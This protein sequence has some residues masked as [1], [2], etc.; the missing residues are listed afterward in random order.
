MI[1]ATAAVAGAEEGQTTE[2]TSTSC[3]A[4]AGSTEGGSTTTDPEEMTDEELVSEAASETA[5]A[6][7]DHAAHENSNDP[8]ERQSL[9]KSEAGHRHRVSELQT[10]WRNNDGKK[11]TER[12]DDD[13]K[14]AMGKED[15]V[16]MP[17][18]PRDMI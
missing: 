16:P 15:C 8:K 10:A 7:A 14:A 9:R 13:F 1:P 5:A 3:S 4:D 2:T 18:D 6:D 12:S 17:I 11:G